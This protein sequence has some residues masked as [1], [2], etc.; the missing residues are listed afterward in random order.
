MLVDYA[1][2]PEVAIALRQVLSRD[3]GLVAYGQR[4]YL[5]AVQTADLATANA[6]LQ[7]L[8]DRNFTALIVDSQSAIL[9]TPVVAK[10]D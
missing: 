1:N 10:L 8:S 4:P 7:S 6:V 9:L 2:Q 3:V 5:L